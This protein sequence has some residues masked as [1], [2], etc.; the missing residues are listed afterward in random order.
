LYATT[1]SQAH[2]V[3][4]QKETSKKQAK[5]ALEDKQEDAEALAAWQFLGAKTEQLWLLSEEQLEK[6]CKEKGIE[7]EGGEE[8]MKKK[9][10]SNKGK[11]RNHGAEKDDD[12]NDDDK[13]KNSLIAALVQSTDIVVSHKRGGGEEEKTKKRPK[14]SVDS[15][16]DNWASLSLSKLKSVLACFGYIPEAGSSKDEIV[17]HVERM[18]CGDDQAE[19]DK[20][21]GGAAGAG[22]NLLL[23]NGEKKLTS[24][25]RKKSK[26]SFSKKKQEVVEISSDSDSDFELEEE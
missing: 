24:S 3:K 25:S 20:T 17:A 6:Q 16:P 4:K 2:G 1:Q 21:G 9:N 14:I 12:D 19:K 15:L 5:L 13:K 22:G 11:K 26:S 18:I 10:N 7:V 23:G 8:D